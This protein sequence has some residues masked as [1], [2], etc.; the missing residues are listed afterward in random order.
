M[1]INRC[2]I[3]TGAV[4]HR[5]L[6]PKDHLLKYRVFSVLLDLDALDEID[7]D[8]MPLNI[9]RLGFLSF[10]ERDHGDGRERGLKEWALKQLVKGKVDI[11]SV[12]VRVLCYPRFLGYVFNP[13]TVFFC[14]NQSGELIAILYQVKN[15]M[16][17]DHTYVVPVQQQN[18]RV[19]RHRCDKAMYVSPF[20]PM[21]SD[22]A[23]NITPPGDDVC[24]SIQQ[25]DREG[26]ILNASFSGKH[27][28]LNTANLRRAII[29][30][31]LMTLKV[32]CGIHVEAFKLW[33][34][35]IPFFRH[36]PQP[37]P[38][39]STAISNSKKEPTQGAL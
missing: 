19:Y 23:F 18:E 15:T 25:S 36:T 32:I 12:R 13:L 16:G 39:I 5:R 35:G 21:E 30:H 6:K 7:A 26:P 4:V 29:R 8:K 34:K 28:P 31:P 27:E 3:Y 14:E 33:R 9:N 20:T 24:V 11:Q 37:G 2:G 1:N 17:E 22:Y 38:N 10:Y